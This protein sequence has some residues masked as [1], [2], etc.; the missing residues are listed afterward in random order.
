MEKTWDDFYKSG[1]VTDYL[2]YRNAISDTAEE[3]RY[4]EEQRN[5]GADSCAYRD[6]TDGHAGGRL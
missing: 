5:N 2:R 6:G 3:Q 1:K 4:Q